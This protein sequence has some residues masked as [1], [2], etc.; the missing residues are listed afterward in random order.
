M[1]AAL[2]GTD[3]QLTVLPVEPRAGHY[4]FEAQEVVGGLAACC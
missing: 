4:A 3:D 2:L 1:R